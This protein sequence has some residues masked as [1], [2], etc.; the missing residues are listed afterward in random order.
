[1]NFICISS[2]KKGGVQLK[3]KITI[4]QILGMQFFYLASSIGF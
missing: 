2:P 4:P 3:Q 1:L